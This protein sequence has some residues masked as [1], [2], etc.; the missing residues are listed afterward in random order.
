MLSAEF[1]GF[2]NER[3]NNQHYVLN[4][5]YNICFQLVDTEKR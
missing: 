2:G 4:E 1:S 5:N 3:E